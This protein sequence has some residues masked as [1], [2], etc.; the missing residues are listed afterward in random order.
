MKRLLAFA[1]M[2]SFTLNAFADTTP[3]QQIFTD[4]DDNTVVI[5][6]PT[7]SNASGKS[8]RITSYSDDRKQILNDADQYCQNMGYGPFA[9][10]RNHTPELE[11][12]NGL[13]VS[14]E[15]HPTRL[16]PIQL[17][18]AIS[19]IRCW[20]LKK[21]LSQTYH[22]KIWDSDFK[23]WKIQ[24]AGFRYK[25]KLYGFSS[26][27]DARTACRLFG[28]ESGG[29]EGGFSSRSVPVVTLNSTNGL[30]E[31]EAVGTPQMGLYCQGNLKLDA[32]YTAS[33]APAPSPNELLKYSHTPFIHVGSVPT[34]DGLKGSWGLVGAWDLSGKLN[35][36]KKGYFSKGIK[37]ADGSIPTLLIQERSIRWHE[38][39]DSFIVQEFQTQNNGSYKQ[40][41][42]ADTIS[43]NEHGLALGLELGSLENVSILQGY[44]R[45]ITLHSVP[46]LIC[47]LKS[48]EDSAVELFLLFQHELKSP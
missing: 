17:G 24:G 33:S 27:T 43:I 28:Y 21:Q 37:N 47:K 14:M 8:Y 2:T 19:E 36:S 13:S 26:N 10:V 38:D 5:T 23:H 4:N 46:H 31:H 20:K 9:T 1:L 35:L 45:S 11:P 32:S 30:Y 15:S 16:H 18:Y 22:Q 7:L 48:Q 42:Q 12:Y 3:V 29:F 25:G 41:Q 34:I 6:H 40:N 44:C 39:A